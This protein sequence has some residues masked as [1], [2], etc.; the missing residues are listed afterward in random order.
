MLNNL[1]KCVEVQVK[2]RD[3]SF[4]SCLSDAFASNQSEKAHSSRTDVKGYLAS[5]Y[6][7]SQALTHQYFAHWVD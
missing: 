5:T 6:E 7:M 1:F 3:I 2:C 4:H